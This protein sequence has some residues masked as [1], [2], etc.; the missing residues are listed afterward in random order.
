MFSNQPIPLWLPSAQLVLVG[1]VL[2]QCLLNSQFHFL[3]L[4]DP[5]VASR[6]LSLQLFV[7]SESAMC[8]P[9]VFL[10]NKWTVYWRPLSVKHVIVQ[11]S[12]ADWLIDWVEYNAPP[13]TI[14]NVCNVRRIAAIGLYT[15]MLEQPI[16]VVDIAPLTCS[17]RT[18]GSIDLTVVEN[19]FIHL[20]IV[21]IRHP[22]ER[23]WNYSTVH[24]QYHT[25]YIEFTSKCLCITVG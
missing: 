12:D 4:D 14:C 11:N 25:R 8:V 19:S 18:Y 7:C 6:Q 5:G 1:A 22:T 24:T 10:H 20:F 21:F 17:R 9:S 15:L 3:F 23:R 13:D 2:S 16:S